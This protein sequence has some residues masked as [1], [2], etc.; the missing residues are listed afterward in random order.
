MYSGSPGTYTRE[1]GY[2]AYY[3]ICEKLRSG[4][5]TE[6][7]DEEGKV[8]YAYGGDQWVGYDNIDSIQYKVPFYFLYQ[9]LFDNLDRERIR[10]LI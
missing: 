3:E 10:F 9:T 1:G 6:Y 2:L 4:E 7:W 8:P 5:F